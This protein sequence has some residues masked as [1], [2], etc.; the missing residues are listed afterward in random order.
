ME[1][2]KLDWVGIFG[3]IGIALV[4]IMLVVIG[5]TNN[6]KATNEK[7]SA[8][9]TIETYYDENNTFEKIVYDPDTSVMYAII[10]GKMITPLFN[11]DGTLKTYKP[12]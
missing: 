5:L 4:I 11:A 10:D 3:R 7:K 1:K 8:F 2:K 6:T 12:E 9:K